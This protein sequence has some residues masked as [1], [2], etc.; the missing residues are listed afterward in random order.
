MLPELPPVD[1]ANLERRW[2]VDSALPHVNYRTLVLVLF[3][4]GL[5]GIFAAARSSGIVLPRLA[6]VVATLVTSVYLLVR[7]RGARRGGRPPA[8]R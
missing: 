7:L 2:R 6:M 5:I 3:A 8:P 4:V 1:L